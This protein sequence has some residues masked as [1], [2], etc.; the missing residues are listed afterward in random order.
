MATTRRRFVQTLAG[1]ASLGVADLETLGNLVARGADPTATAPDIIRFGPDIEPI[2]RLIEETPRAQC[3]GALVE[4]LRLG[5]PY[6]RL[7][8]AAYYAGIRKQKTNHVVY[9][10]PSV[11]QVSVDLRPELKLLPLFWAVDVYKQQQEDF[12]TPPQTVLK[13]PFPSAEKAAAEFLDAMQQA[14]LERS[15]QAIVALAR[16][17][18]A[19]QTMEQLWP[20][21][22]R[23]GGAGGHGAIAVASCCRALDTIGWQHAESALRFVVQNVFAWAGGGK[24][25]R[26]FPVNTSRVDQHLD[27][28]P[29]GWAGGEEN[30]VATHELFGLLR[31]GQAE[32]ACELATK[33]LLGGVRAQAIWD[34]VHLATAELMVRHE[35]GWGLASRPLHAN[36]SA[37]ALHYAFRTSESARTRLL[38]LLQ[39]VAW[40]GDKT[41]SDLGIK[42]LR[43]IKLCELPSSPVPADTKTAVA[44]IF[45]LLPERSYRWDPQA[46]TA[47]TAYGDRAAADEASRKVFALVKSRPETAPRFAETARN[48]LCQKSTGDSHDY[49][50]LAAIL[51]EAEWVSPAWQPHL[52]AASVHFFHGEQGP[53]HPAVQQAREALKKERVPSG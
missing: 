45:S 3:V 48:W 15:E 13:G 10:I 17:Q 52:L 46:K 16:S 42:S 9:M 2:V 24:P 28:L 5:L 33:Q 44:E 53:D 12:P 38:V 11:H 7:L 8:S 34:A 36:T 25:D 26:Y 30:T 39:A 29:P 31:T 35:S 23:N 21:G 22:C 49:K 32:Q 37:N 20:V 47:V 51:E 18:G 40:A 1:A 43:D 19:R 14:D 41:G 6:R 50:F 27:K 4:Q